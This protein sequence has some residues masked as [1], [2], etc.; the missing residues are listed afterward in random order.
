MPVSNTW[1]A[2]LQH[3]CCHLASKACSAATA[4]HAARSAYLVC[5]CVA[6]VRSWRQR[7]RR[8]RWSC[9][10][11][12]AVRAI[13]A[14]GSAATVPGLCVWPCPHALV[15]LC[16]LRHAPQGDQKAQQAAGAEHAE[17]P[18]R[19]EGNPHVGWVPQP[20]GCTTRQ[21]THCREQPLP[22]TMM[23]VPGAENCLT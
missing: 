14:C 6:A 5:R 19:E 22:G 23:P 13:D 7:R 18:V 11:P 3:P 2:L 9:T 10:L 8:R 16:A 17:R 21:L 1:P 4:C 20:H 12:G 15:V